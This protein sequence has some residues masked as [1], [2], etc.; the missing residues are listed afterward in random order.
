ML[1][2]VYGPTTIPPVGEENLVDGIIG[3][4]FAFAQVASILNSLSVQKGELQDV[5]A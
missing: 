4:P 3:K 1:V 2:T 5:G